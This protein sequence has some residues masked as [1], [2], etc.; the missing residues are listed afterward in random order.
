[1]TY[2][3]STNEVIITGLSN[4]SSGGQNWAG[5]SVVV[6]LTVSDPSQ[7]YVKST[8]DGSLIKVDPVTAAQ[9]YATRDQGAELISTVRFRPTRSWSRPTSSI[10]LAYWQSCSSS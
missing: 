2:V 6:P 8:S 1:M 3:P 9:L 4:F 5:V 10:I 7:F